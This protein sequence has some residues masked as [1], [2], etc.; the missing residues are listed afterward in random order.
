VPRSIR[1][2]AAV[3]ISVLL[4]AANGWA[5][6]KAYAG[7]TANPEVGEVK[8]DARSA[9]AKEATEDE[10]TLISKGYVKIGTVTASQDGKKISAEM[11]ERL[12]AAALAKAAE[13]GGDLVRFE[14]KGAPDWWDEPQFKRACTETHTS[15]SYGTTVSGTE[16]ER[17]EETCIKSKVEEA[18]TKRKIDRIE[19]RGAVWRYDLELAKSWVA[20]R[21]RWPQN[22]KLL[23]TEH[24]ASSIRTV[25]S[26][27]GLIG[28]SIDD[29]DVQSWLFSTSPSLPSG[30]PM[31]PW[32]T[33]GDQIY[34]SSN[35]GIEFH[36]QHITRRLTEIV[37]DSTYQG[38]LPYGLRYGR[39]RND[40]EVALDSVSLGS[41]EDRGLGHDTYRSQGL[42][43]GFDNGDG[44]LSLVVLGKPCQGV[45]SQGPG[46]LLLHA[47]AIHGDS[48]EGKVVLAQGADV[49]A[50]DEYGDTPLHHAAMLGHKEMAELLLA[51]RANVRAEDKYGFTP[52]HDAARSGHKEVAELLL[53]QGADVNAKADYGITPLH[54]AAKYGQKEVAELLLAK[55]A[56][57]NAKDSSSE[58]PLHEAAELDLSDNSPQVESGKRELAELLLAKGADVN[59]KDRDGQTPLHYAA[60]SGNMEGAQFLLANGANINATDGRGRTPLAS[61]IDMVK[62]PL[63]AEARI[64]RVADLL[65]QHG[66]H[67]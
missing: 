64:K 37:L 55:G 41:P 67:E 65:R 9:P 3:A 21:A 15:T 66:G 53:A 1:F 24:E 51:K 33:K 54:L 12:N 30:Q 4:S 60:W 27:C 13:V 39:K 56:D 59:A 10:A 7:F 44:P 28:K 63:P 8:L 18:G 17:K 49:N 19:S 61:A 32:E 47:A 23:T 31:Y 6:T 45:E 43:V 2:G 38:D 62:T 11:T 35:E 22:P 16:Y 26:L 25:A 36:F 40:V 14:A 58:T 34:K 52:L 48:E 46:S 5:Q 50:K 29:H 42:F 20:E 57:V